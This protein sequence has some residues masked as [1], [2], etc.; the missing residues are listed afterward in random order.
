MH[1]TEPRD[2]YGAALGAVRRLADAGRFHAGEAIVVT[3]LAAEVGYSATP[4]REALACLAGQGLIERRRGRGYFYPALAP[5]EIIDLFELQHAYVHA[6]LTL[7]PR[8][9]A[10]LRKAVVGLEPREGPQAVFAAIVAQSTNAA[11]TAAHQRVVDRLKTVIEAERAWADDNAASVR[12]M[13]AAV[14]DGRIDSLLTHIDAL[15]ERRCA[16]TPALVAAPA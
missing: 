16:R 4:V 3:E 1:Y 8:G 2:P 7:H 5:A 14:A 13:I 12:A 9:L 11:L 6:A 15:H 10:L